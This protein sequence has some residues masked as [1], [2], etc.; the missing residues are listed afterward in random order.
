MCDR[1]DW[2]KYLTQIGKM[3]E[4]YKYRNLPILDSISE[5]VE[6]NE[7]ITEKQKETI[8]DISL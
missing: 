2:E 1:C 4:S 6:E 5:W 8:D 3:Q 7:H